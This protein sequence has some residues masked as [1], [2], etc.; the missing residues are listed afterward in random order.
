MPKIKEWFSF[1]LELGT[2]E[3][4]ELYRYDFIMEEEALG[5]AK[6]S[7]QTAKDSITK[8]HKESSLVENSFPSPKVR[9]LFLSTEIVDERTYIFSKLVYQPIKTLTVNKQQPI[10]KFF[11]GRYSVVRVTGEKRG[12]WGKVRTIGVKV[13]GAENV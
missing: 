1:I 13:K 11:R 4:P 10:L 6:F 2:E 12:D 5:L 3:K 7:V 9:D 8:E